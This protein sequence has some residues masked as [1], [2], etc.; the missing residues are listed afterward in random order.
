MMAPYTRAWAFW[1]FVLLSPIVTAWSWGNARAD[2]QKSARRTICDLHY[3]VQIQ[4]PTAHPVTLYGVLGLDPFAAPFYPPHEAGGVHLPSYETMR[5]SLFDT[6]AAQLRFRNLHRR[7][8]GRTPGELIRVWLASDP[9]HLQR[10]L[11]QPDTLNMRGPGTVS[12]H[13][14]SV[15]VLRAEAAL[16]LL[17][18]NLRDVYSRV[19]IPALLPTEPYDGKATSMLMRMKSGAAKLFSPRAQ[20]TQAGLGRLQMLQA[21]DNICAPT[22]THFKMFY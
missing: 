21:L 1:L 9:K 6:V 19:F 22:G 13:R 5:R 12:Y 8:Y 4:S 20:R 16:V 17:D 7:E 18:D 2:T 11:A 3:K 10:Y 14:A 15:W